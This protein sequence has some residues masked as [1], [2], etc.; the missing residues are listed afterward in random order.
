M[1]L[2]NWKKRDDLKRDW[3]VFQSTEAFGAAMSVLEGMAKPFMSPQES[4]ESLAKRQAYLA[5]FHDCIK[6]LQS[7]PTMSTKAGQ[8]VMLQEWA[9]ATPPD[10][11]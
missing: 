7:I 10:D 1:T 5:G 9:W 6:M 4:I 8:E 2:A 11:K 3:A